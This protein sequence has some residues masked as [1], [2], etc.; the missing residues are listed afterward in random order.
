MLKIPE[1]DF[2]PT[3]GSSNNFCLPMAPLKT[4]FHDLH[5]KLGGKLVNYAGYLLPI[6]YAHQTHIQSHHQVRK[7][8]GLF[9]VSHM[10]QHRLVGP[11]AS[12]FLET[13][14]PTDISA[15]A[16][17]YCHLSTFLNTNGGIVDDTI[18][19]K[20]SENEIYFVSNGATS[21]KVDSFIRSGLASFGGNLEYSNYKKALVAL[22]GPKA[23]AVLADVLKTDVSKV[24]F[25]QHFFYADGKTVPAFTN[26]L[27]N[28]DGI[29][30]LRSGYTGEDGFEISIPNP[31]YANS[32]VNKILLLEAVE[33]IGL[34]ARDS[35]RLEAGMCLYGNELTEEITPV[36]ASLNWL[37]SKLRRTPDANFNGASKILA[38]L[39]DKSLVPYKRVGFQFEGGS[40]ARH[41]SKVYA[42]GK[43]VGFVSSGSESPTLSAA[44]GKRVNIGQAYVKMPYN[45]KETPI[46]VQVRKKTVSATVKKMPLVESH[47]YKGN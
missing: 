5:L 18:I 16:P 10:L 11:D 8:A 28:S 35:L 42:E 14:T 7:L 39:K 12:K 32:L 44:L 9:D 6:S 23:A 15:I 45:K 36:E 21:D 4:A 33:P 20:V 31:E 43:E 2:H 38:Q 34:A 37:I 26:Y 17:G 41:G 1:S 47:Y 3:S 13:L 29:L 30:I 19:T 40:A 46:D 22:Q 27:D 24:Y 25:G